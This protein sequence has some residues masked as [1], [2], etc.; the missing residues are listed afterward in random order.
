MKA[1]RKN[2]KLIS[3]GLLLT[4]VFEILA[5]V[6]LLA[7]TDSENQ[8][9]YSNASGGGSEMVNMYN[10]ALNYSLPLMSIPGQNIGYN[11]TLSYNSD[12]SKML[13]TSSFVG[14]GWN[15]NLGS[16][17][18]QVQAVPDDFKGDQILYRNHVKPYRSVDIGLGE[19]TSTEYGGMVLSLPGDTSCTPKSS[20]TGHLYWDNYTG[21]GA[22]IGYNKSGALGPLSVGL[23]IDTKRGVGYNL[24]GSYGFINAGISG[25]FNQG[26]S[27]ASLG[28][29]GTGYQGSTGILFNT[30]VSAPQMPMHTKIYSG[31]AKFGMNM[32]PPYEVTN[33]DGSK[34]TNDFKKY[35]KTGGFYIEQ[36]QHK[37]YGL[38]GSLKVTYVKSTVKQEYYST[39]AYGYLYKS[40][41]LSANNVKDF[42][43]YNL[44]YTKGTEFLPVSQLGNDIFVQNDQGSGGVFT[45]RTKN[46]DVWS[47]TGVQSTTKQK[48]LGGEFSI[49][50]LFAILEDPATICQEAE[51]V[52]ANPAFHAGVNFLTG[53]GISYGGAFTN[54]STNKS[55]LK[56]ISD[57]SYRLPL[58]KNSE[59]YIERNNEKALIGFGDDEPRRMKVDRKGSFMSG[60]Q[61]YYVLPENENE[62]KQTSWDVFWNGGNGS[63]ATSSSFV[64][65]KVADYKQHSYVQYLTTSE[66]ISYGR[67]KSFGYLSKLKSDATAN[68]L[69]AGDVL[70]SDLRGDRSHHIAEINVFETNGLIYTYGE[71]IYNIQRNDAMFSL[72]HEEGGDW[73]GVEVNQFEKPLP[74]ANK[75]KNGVTYGKAKPVSSGSDLHAGMEML[76]VSMVPEYVATWPA[77]MITSADYV[78]L[79]GNGPS[80]DDLGGWVKFNYSQQDEIQ[81]YRWRTPYSNV[82]VTDGVKGQ[83]G[84]DM[85]FYRSGI[86]DVKYITSIETKTHI[87]VFHYSDRKDGHEVASEL[88]GGRG[89]RSLKKLDYIE[90]FL[91]RLDL[92]DG[93]TTLV[94]KVN[95]EYDY[96]VCPNVPDN[97]GATYQVD[98]NVDG[99]LE[100]GN[101]NAG[102]LT[103]RKVYT[104]FYDSNKGENYKYEFNYGINTTDTDPLLHTQDTLFNPSYNRGNLD[105]WGNFKKNF[106]ENG[107]PVNANYPFQDFS[108]TEE[109]DSKNANLIGMPAPWCLRE[110]LLPTGA[111]MEF[112]YENRDYAYVEDKPATKMYD[113]VSVDNLK[114]IKKAVESGIDLGF[115]FAPAPALTSSASRHVTKK[116]NKDLTNSYDEDGLT[117]IGTSKNHVAIKLPFQEFNNLYDD[118][119]RRDYFYKNYIQGIEKELYIKAYVFLEDEIHHALTSEQEKNYDFVELMSKI[120]DDTLGDIP[121]GVYQFGNEYYGLIDLDP[122]FPQVD[123]VNIAKMVATGKILS[124]A[125]CT[126]PIGAIKAAAIEHIKTKRPELYYGTLGDKASIN[127]IHA[128]NLINTAITGMTCTL[129][130]QGYA[131]YIRFNGWS[132][133]RLKDPRH[134]QAG[135]NVEV[136]KI[137][138]GYRIKTVTLN[139][140]WKEDAPEKPYSYK[141]SYEYTMYEGEGTEK[142]LISSGVAIEPL[143]AR[144]ENADYKLYYYQ[145]KIPLAEN[146]TR[147]IA[148]HPLDMYNTGVSVGY[149][150]VTVRNQYPAGL[151]SQIKKSIAPHTVYEF[152]TP[153]EFPIIK[154]STQTTAQNNPMKYMHSIAGVESTNII[155]NMVSQGYTVVKND[156]A[157]KL[158]SITQLTREGDNVISSQTYKYFSNNKTVNEW[159]YSPNFKSMELG[160]AKVVDHLKNDGIN[161]LNSGVADTA[162]KMKMEEI[163]IGEDYDVWLDVNENSENMDETGW[164]QFNAGLTSVPALLYIMPIFFMPHNTSSSSD[165]QVV[166]NKVISRRGILQQVITQKDQS[167]IR[168]EYLAYDQETAAPLLT[169]VD[170]EWH[171]T[172]AQKEQSAITAKEPMIYKFTR[173][174]YWE[175]NYNPINGESVVETPFLGAYKTIDKSFAN[176]SIVGGNI[177]LAPNTLTDGDK[178]T[179][180]KGSV[181]YIGYILRDEVSKQYKLY[182]AD[183]SAIEASDVSEFRVIQ[184]GNTNLVNT[185]VGELVFKD[186]NLSASK[187]LLPVSYLNA[188]A[189]TFGGKWDR[190]CCDTYLGQFSN[191]TFINGSRN[192]WMPYQSFVFHNNRDYSAS[193]FSQRGLISNFTSFNWQTSRSNNWVLSSTAVKY[194]LWNNLIQKKDALGLS[195]SSIYGYGKMA[196]TGVA[197]N[198]TRKEFGLENFEEKGYMHCNDNGNLGISTNL[199]FMD[200]LNIKGTITNEKSHTGKYSLK[201]NRDQKIVISNK[202]ACESNTTH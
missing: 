32:N 109:A 98:I 38:L 112:E 63:Y 17:T 79:T 16:I 168:T 196:V 135:T 11:L 20:Y 149:R 83:S 124:A 157:G 61:K 151:E 94:Q 166:L 43:R 44:S 184:S 37:N 111:S 177:Q 131:N 9:E 88:D 21:L 178:V 189:I 116:S 85:G 70:N 180:K 150:K 24:S 119:A 73:E 105:R 195:S 80:K 53:D 58:V 147:Y 60:Q 181:V 26:L 123:P 172:N 87:A 76:N 182:N 164:V 171:S 62:D 19:L 108:Y 84:D 110:V 139:D 159:S 176:L 165:K 39:P 192:K 36:L 56:N 190:E 30:M 12:E 156:M 140:N 138:G 67:S 155:D 66:A 186:T 89:S 10:G 126:D 129:L 132:K 74:S 127:P 90:L 15:L 23:E 49:S 143:T 8:V 5:P 187:V 57:D 183:F 92:T 115:G 18:R 136:N 96:S 146:N 162:D 91:K 198:A 71:P 40:S 200:L 188:S 185:T 29:S 100:D 128:L 158:K 64:N 153:K 75:I 50:N 27:S 78:D 7:N 72:Q 86:K 77:S 163:R 114:G 144:E 93:S 45:A 81:D 35:F 46:F 120:D 141:Q 59:I 161:S 51:P 179:Y 65:A 95:F 167:E 3:S 6:S 25:Q 99:V 31:H 142:H 160:G 193:S 4:M 170:N 175:Y 169:R 197:S 154:K 121:Y 133:I 102:K 55:N 125:V 103:L 118:D 191:N 34:E 101:Q 130:S 68:R 107:N 13:N 14:F 134:I 137:G 22:R 28:Y 106:D 113:I 202:I 122:V 82:Q 97:N 174:A 173:P 145:E 2:A 1:L 201:V 47:T 148:G 54:S 33:P 42:T 104:T 194:D 41:D 69:R 152:F 48:D 117:S 199:P 52:L